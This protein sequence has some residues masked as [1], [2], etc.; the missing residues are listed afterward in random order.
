MPHPLKLSIAEETRIVALLAS[1][2]TYETIKAEFKGIRNLSDPTIAKVKK[3]NKENLDMIAER[4][5]QRQEQDAA[6]IKQK[7]NKL[8]A[9]RL[10]QSDEFQ[11]LLNAT[12]DDFKSGKI[13]YKTYQDKIK[14]FRTLSV[15]ELVS[16]SREMHTQSGTEPAKE[17]PHKDLQALVAAIRSGDEVRL[18]E[19]VFKSKDGDDISTTLEGSS[20]PT[21]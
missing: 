1:G 8:I 18:S 17:T 11:D 10:D 20:S 15:S 19:M 3:R 2:S 21:S 12:L 9:K 4:M 5:L 7:A 13:D 6:S 16:V 14:A